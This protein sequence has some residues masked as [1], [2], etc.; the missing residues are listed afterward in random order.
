MDTLS[1]ISQISV[2]KDK[3]NAYCNLLGTTVS[4]RPNPKTSD[5]EAIIAA[6][7]AETTV[8]A[9]QVLSELVKLLREQKFEDGEVLQAMLKG[10][11]AV[12]SARGVTFDE[13]VL[14]SR[15][16]RVDIS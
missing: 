13:Q 2:Q 10:S 11:L 6:A 12:I 8:V 1:Q 16:L 9:R 5:V 4:A 15:Q 14:Q 3:A 7:V